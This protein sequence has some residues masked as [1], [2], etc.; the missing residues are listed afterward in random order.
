MATLLNAVTTDTVG[1]LTS[2]TGPATVFIHGTPA[3]A[4]VVIE[5]SPTTNTTDVVKM[6]KSLIPQGIMVDRTGA[7]NVDGYG[8]YYIRAV[9]E[10]SSASTSVTVTSTQ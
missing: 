5:A 8:T 10:N 6:D 2:H 3:G 7:V 9:L 4:T 1:T